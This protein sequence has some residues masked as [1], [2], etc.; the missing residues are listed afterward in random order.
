MLSAARWC[1]TDT[2]RTKLQRLVRSHLPRLPMCRIVCW[3]S[4]TAAF[5][6]QQLSHRSTASTGLDNDANTLHCLHFSRNLSLFRMATP[7]ANS[8]RAWKKDSISCNC[9]ACDLGGLRCWQSDRT[10]KIAQSDMCPYL[11]SLAVEKFTQ[12]RPSLLNVSA[13]DSWLQPV[14]TAMGL[15]SAVSGRVASNYIA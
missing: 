6:Q 10:C 1:T 12:P 5:R 8:K 15:S 2:G 11:T 3:R 4:T 7:F 13:V 14:V 9:P